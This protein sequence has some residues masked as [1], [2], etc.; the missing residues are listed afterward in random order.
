[1]FDLEADPEEMRNLVGYENSI[2]S[3]I[4][5]CNVLRQLL[6]ET[7]YIARP[8]PDTWLIGLT[9]SYA[10]YQAHA[11]QPGSSRRPPLLM[12]SC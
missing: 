7:D 9:N 8:S 6:V 5:M 1:L 11:I 4:E 3:H 2:N 10:T 12:P